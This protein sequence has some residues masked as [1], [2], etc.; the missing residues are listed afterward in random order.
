M[1]FVKQ[2]SLTAQFT[3]STTKPSFVG[4]WTDQTTDYTYE[5]ELERIKN[6]RVASETTDEVYTCTQH[7]HSHSCTCKDHQFRANK[8]FTEA[9]AKG[10]SP[11][12][13]KHVQALI[14][15]G[16]FVKPPIKYNIGTVT[17]FMYETDNIAD[18]EKIDGKLCVPVSKTG[19]K[20]VEVTCVMAQ[21]TL[22]LA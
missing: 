6:V 17:K 21:G 4:V 1:A 3:N 22:Q 18:L 12:V 13:C 8:R 19:G 11:K 15:V 14:D 16:V 2:T 20:I 10:T 9:L 5:Y 7:P